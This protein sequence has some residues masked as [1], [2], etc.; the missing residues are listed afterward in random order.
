MEKK[1]HNKENDMARNF[2]EKLVELLKADARFVDDDGNLI[3][4]AVI[5]RAWKIDQLETLH[6]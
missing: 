6:G 5:E 3:R 1:S 2:N 4:A